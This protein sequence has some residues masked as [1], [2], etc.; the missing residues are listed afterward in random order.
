MTAAPLL[1]ESPVGARCPAAGTATP[2]SSNTTA[3]N[4]VI[5]RRIRVDIFASHEVNKAHRYERVTG[6]QQTPHQ[7][8]PVTRQGQ[9][10]S[11]PDFQDFAAKSTNPAVF[12]IDR[13]L[14]YT[15]AEEVSNQH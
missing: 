2:C 13:E 14:P 3:S 4:R 10:K 7:C 6:G 12:G 5:M 9:M 11:V 8:M 1:G 15:G